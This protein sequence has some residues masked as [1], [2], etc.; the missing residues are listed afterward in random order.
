MSAEVKSSQGDSRIRQ[1]EVFDMDKDGADDLVVLFENGELDIFYGGTRIDS[2]GKKV[3]TFTN[4]LVDSSLKIH[5]S[6]EKRDDG[7]AIYFDGL[8]QLADTNGQSQSQADFYKESEALS[9]T[10]V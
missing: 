2:T 1:M 6:T 9:D 5:I 3:V 8:P 4:K 7:G 10:S